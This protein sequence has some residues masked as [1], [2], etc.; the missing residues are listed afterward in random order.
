MDEYYEMMPGIRRS[1]LWKL[2]KSPLHF[3]FALEHPT[4]QTPALL[5]GSAAHKL[6]L[7]ADDFFNEYAL[8][9]VLDRRTK[10]GKAEWAAFV[11]HC[12]ENH[13]EVIPAADYEMIKEMSAAIDAHPVARQLLTGEHEKIFMWTDPLTGEI[14]KVKVD[15]ITEYNG[16]KYIVDYKTTDSC[17]DG[18]FERSCRRYGYKFQ[19]GMYREGVFQNTLE[20]YGFA[21]VA[22]EKTEP[23]AV[24]V[25]FCTDEWIDEGY[26]EFRW[27]I[28]LYHDC[29]VND[30]WPGYEDETILQEG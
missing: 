18:H 27:L 21:F 16:K 23:F 3:K 20:Q 26:D 14:C 19:A 28:G 4:P 22:Q 8:S 12:E 10:E 9:P 13:L 15:C 29:K 11:A 1:D 5:F 17:E 30:R 6:I 25:Y 24:R 7:E 2:N